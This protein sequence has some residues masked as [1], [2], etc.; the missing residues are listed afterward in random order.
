MTKLLSR[1][2]LK[3]FNTADLGFTLKIDDATMRELR[4]MEVER[5]L[6]LVRA[7]NFLLD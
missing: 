2:R 3:T 5:A 7:K 1:N 6:A 4:Q